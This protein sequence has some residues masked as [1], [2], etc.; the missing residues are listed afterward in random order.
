M[1]NEDWYFDN[2]NENIIYG[3]IDHHDR[4]VEHARRIK[5]NSVIRRLA[6]DHRIDLSTLPVVLGNAVA[7]YRTQ[8]RTTSQN[9]Y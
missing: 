4:M 1:D 3:K 7:E 8:R 5:K 9:K 6:N 2:V